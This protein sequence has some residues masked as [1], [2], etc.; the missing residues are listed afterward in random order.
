MDENEQS[1][2]KPAKKRTPPWFLGAFVLILLTVLV[3]LQASNYWKDF[4]IESASDT[5]LLYA[6]SSLNFFAFIVFGFIFIRSLLKLRRERR[7]M[8]IGSKI[9]TKL[10]LYFFAISL[11]PIIAMAVFSYLFMN[12]AIERWFKQIPDNVI[13]EARR[14]Q[15]QSVADQA[16]RLQKTADMIAVELEKQEIT[17]PI[18]QKLIEAGNLTK[19]EILS[20]TGD[21]IVASEKNLVSAQKTELEK[22]LEFVHRKDF[23][24]PILKDGKLFDAAVTELSNGR[25]LVV[26]PDL[27]PSENVSQM[28]ENSLTE[29]ERLKQI[30]I[31]VR[32][33]G[34]LTLGVLT[35]LLIFAS[36]WTAFYIARGLTVPIRA[37]AEGAD[38]I[39]RGDFAHRVS[40]LAEDELALLVLTFNQMSAK[41]EENSA[42]LEERRKYIET[43]LQS[44]STGVISLD[45]KNR[46]T[47]INKAA[48]QMLKIENADF[49][50]FGL[51]HL[52]NEENRLVLERLLRRAKRIGQASEQTILQRENANLEMNESLPVILSATALPK[53]VSGESR[54]IVLVIEDLSELI[55]AQRAS[56]W[57]EVARRMAHEIKNPLTPIQ[58]SAERIAKRIADGATQEIYSQINTGKDRFENKDLNPKPKDQTAKIIKD[59]T[60]TI[61]REVNSLKSMVDEFSRFA[62]L[63]NVKLEKGS[64]NETIEQSVFLYEDR[65][66]GIRIKM[67]LEDKI[68]SVMID[69]EQLRRVFVNLIDN[70]IEAFDETQAEKQICIKTFHD[71]ARDL[72]VA[73]VS[74]NG[75]GISPAGFQKLF[76]PYFSTKG[77][78]TG[79]GLAIVQRIVNEHHGR[80]KAVSNKPRGAKFIIELPTLS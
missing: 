69:E 29:L 48:I 43:V 32:R 74:D 39:A 52:V 17:E 36:S 19:L 37:L 80:I 56:A 47:T 44:L 73:E 25:A 9:K 34:F 78:E 70:A 21:V 27:R 18:L 5:L 15:N 26:V 64:V 75:N 10:L 35:F 12:R 31:G 2:V 38:K 66:P 22:T 67:N 63:P 59:G 1:Q 68:P 11:L 13:S 3:L 6:L 76:Q 51:E 58:L 45:G 54:G 20:K 30:Q 60:E 24:R 65:F 14:V 8:Q 62:R 42:E 33:I 7:A 41:L 55:A 61:L 4:E 57:A 49:P 46:V 40:V 53:T 16:L 79:L 23:N 77:R 71:A 72:I 28:F 50:E